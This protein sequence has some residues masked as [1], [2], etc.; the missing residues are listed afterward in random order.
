MRGADRLVRGEALYDEPFP[1][2]YPNGN[3]YG[4]ANYLLYV[5]FEFAFPSVHACNH[6]VPARAAAVTFDLLTGLG[7][8]LLGRRLRPKAVLI[9]SV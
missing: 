4:P 5:P 2:P 1:K 7:L 3:T 6:M 9:S 8:F